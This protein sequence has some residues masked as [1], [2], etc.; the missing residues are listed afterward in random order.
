MK[1]I[2]HSSP[3]FGQFIHKTKLL[4]LLPL[5][6]MA[7]QKYVKHP[8]LPFQLKTIILQVPM[9]TN[10]WSYALPFI[11]IDYA[12]CLI[13]KTMSGQSYVT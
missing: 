13:I 6:S 9:L 4:F 3:P 1:S 11:E 7:K 8:H 10:Q 12:T 2:G 5:A